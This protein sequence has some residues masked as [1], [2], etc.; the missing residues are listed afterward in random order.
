MSSMFIWGSVGFRDIRRSSE[1]KMNNEKDNY[2]KVYGFQTVENQK[3]TSKN[4]GNWVATR[5]Y[6]DRT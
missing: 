3:A 4:S 5:G 6:G 2:Y 1:T